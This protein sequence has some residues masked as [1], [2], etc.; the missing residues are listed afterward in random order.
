MFLYLFNG[1]TACHTRD[2]SLISHLAGTPPDY[3]ELY[4]KRDLNYETQNNYNMSIYAE[5]VYG[6][7][8]LPPTDP[9]RKPFKTR[10]HKVQV[11]VIDINEPPQFH[12][13]KSTCEVY[14]NTVS[15]RVKKKHCKISDN[16]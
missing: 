16:V 5:D 14:E 9:K 8:T 10:M 12:E 15:D 6:N 1:Q 4:V 13:L 3:H 2:D 7:L 11:Q